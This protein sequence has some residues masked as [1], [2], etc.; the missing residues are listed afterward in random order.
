MQ[1]LAFEVAPDRRVLGE[2]RIQSED[3]KAMGLERCVLN[4]HVQ[5]MFEKFGRTASF[6]GAAKGTTDGDK[7]TAMTP[8]EVVERPLLEA[9]PFLEIVPCSRSYLVD[10]T[11]PCFVVCG[12]A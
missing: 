6:R 4:E 7:T 9:T 1:L 5:V 3:L 2:V 10:A 8:V 12:V 11:Y